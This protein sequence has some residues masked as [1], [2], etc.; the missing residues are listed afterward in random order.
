MYVSAVALDKTGTLTEGR[1]RLTDVIP[2][3]PLLNSGDVLRWAAIAEAGSGHPIALPILAE[4][5]EVPR[6]DTLRVHAGRGVA[7]KYQDHDILVG[8]IDF[9][10]R[11]GVAI[12]AAARA[13][14]DRLASAGKT[15]VA[16]ALDGC[17]IG[18]LAIADT[19]RE[20]ASGIAG[21]IGGEGVRRIA[22]LTGDH[23]RAAHAIAAEA[24]ILE[25]A[26]RRS[27]ERAQRMPGPTGFNLLRLLERR[28]DNVVY[29]AGYARTRSM[30]RQVV[31]HRHVLVN[32]G[33]V[34]IPSYLVKPG[35]T[36]ELT[37]G[38]KEIPVIREEMMTRGVTASWLAREGASIRVTGVPHREDVEAD[39]REDLIVEFY[40]R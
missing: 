18:V 20:S 3:D 8:G 16:V 12:P 19:E 1:P 30:A 36:V 28:L 14:L 7:S 26:L 40:A 6:A 5:G 22:L 29:R 10:S 2:L 4:A 23:A 25:R 37:P 9:L 35:D 21:R 39:I 38:A 15:A 13:H 31:S 17:A 33:P 32:G 24:G 27:F 11:S 34:N